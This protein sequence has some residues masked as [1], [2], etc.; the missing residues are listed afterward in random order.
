MQNWAGD[1]QS[2]SAFKFELSVGILPYPI[3]FLITD[4]I[5][6]IYGR[7]RA[8]QT[9]IAGLFAALFTLLIVTV[10][11]AATA[12]PW[13]PIDNDT[14]SSV[15]GLTAAAVG[16]S[17]TAYILAQFIDVRIYHFWKKAT[18]GKMLWV[19]NNFSTIASQFVDTASVLILLCLTNTIAWERFWELFLYGFL[20][21]ILVALLDTP[22]LYLCVYFFRKKLNLK[23]GEEVERIEF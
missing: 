13:S 6:E 16:A 23:V 4:C 18:K 14:F 2:L 17:M 8:N 1:W 7:K 20:F 12:T 19:R 21:K 15:F 9:V 10:A 22:L 3:T 5:S 11:N